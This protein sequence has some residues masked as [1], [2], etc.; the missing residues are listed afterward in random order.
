MSQWELRRGGATR[1]RLEKDAV[2]VESHCLG[3]VKIPVML[4]G[5]H[6]TDSV[7]K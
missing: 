3:I 6:G 4:H 2:S 7:G 5:I 1:C